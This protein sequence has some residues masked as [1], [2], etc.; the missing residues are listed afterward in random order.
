MQ[1]LQ[2]LQDDRACYRDRHRDTRTQWESNFWDKE[3][4]YKDKEIEKKRQQLRDLED[5]K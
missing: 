2:K 5:S 4:K 3:V 1:E